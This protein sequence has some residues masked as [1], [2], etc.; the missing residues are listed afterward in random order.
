[1]KTLLSPGLSSIAVSGQPQITGSVNLYSGQG[2]VVYGY[3]TT[4][5]FR[6]QFDA[7]TPTN[8]Y[9]SSDSNYTGTSW[10]SVLQLSAR[11][12]VYS[13]AEFFICASCTG[14]SGI[15]LTICYSNSSV[16][17]TYGSITGMTNSVTSFRTELHQIQQSQTATTNEWITSSSLVGWIR[18]NFAGTASNDMDFDNPFVVYVRPVDSSATATIYKGSYIRW[19]TVSGAL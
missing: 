7:Q 14:T 6:I 4:S 18:G 1:M 16:A 12:S 2:M 13:G 9:K 11:P 17:T 5:G 8:T 19:Q 3:Q 10:N 15:E